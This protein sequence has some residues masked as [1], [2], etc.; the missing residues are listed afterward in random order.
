MTIIPVHVIRGHTQKHHQKWSILKAEI[1]PDYP[2]EV[3]QS[4]V[5]GG[6][7]T[8]TIVQIEYTYVVF[9]HLQMSQAKTP[10]TFLHFLFLTIQ[11]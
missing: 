8:S 5:I 6:I 2:P 1:I 9:F 4:R 11:G 7:W 3:V 10:L